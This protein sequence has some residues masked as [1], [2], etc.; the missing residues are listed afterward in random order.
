[1]SRRGATGKSRPPPPLDEERKRRLGGSLLDPS[2][3]PAQELAV[4]GDPRA[5]RNRQVEPTGDV[6]EV[7]RPDRPTERPREVGMRRSDPAPERALCGLGLVDDRDQLEIRLTERHD[8][9]GRPPAGVTAALDR[10][11]TV[12]TFELA[13]GGGQVGHRNEYV[14]ELQSHERT[15]TG[16]PSARSRYAALSESS[17][18]IALP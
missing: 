18:S 4:P 16:E 10:S 2:Q 12:P 5:S 8:P 17:R 6:V 3:P 1:M 7:G 13:R 11:Q 14:V 9:V 15:R